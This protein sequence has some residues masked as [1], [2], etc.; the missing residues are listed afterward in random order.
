MFLSYNEFGNATLCWVGKQNKLVFL[1]LSRIGLSRTPMPS[2]GNL[3]NIEQ[4]LLGENGLTGEV[5]S[6]IG[7]SAVN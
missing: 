2:L 4:L 7:N 5:P 3:T 6:Y 1:G